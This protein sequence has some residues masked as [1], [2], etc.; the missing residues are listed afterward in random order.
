M[1]IS[2]LDISAETSI[3]LAP[4]PTSGLFP[5]AQTDP[6]M[7]AATAQGQRVPSEASS[8]TGV[9]GVT[10]SCTLVRISSWFG[11]TPMI[12]VTG[13]HVFEAVTFFT[14][15]LSFGLRFDRLRFGQRGI[16]GGLDSAQATSRKKVPTTAISDSVIMASSFFGPQWMTMM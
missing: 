6:T 14:R 7:T 13:S 16:G 11:Q 8:E 3:Q 10:P 12:F 1:P 4:A 9:H 5:F 2:I 15:L